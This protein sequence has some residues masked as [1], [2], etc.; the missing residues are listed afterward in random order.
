MRKG[1]WVRSVQASGSLTGVFRTLKFGTSNAGRVQQVQV[2]VSGSLYI[3]PDKWQS[4]RIYRSC[5]LQGVDLYNQF[6]KIKTPIL[7]CDEYTVLL[8]IFLILY[9]LLTEMEARWRSGSALR[10]Q[11]TGPKFC[12][13]T[14]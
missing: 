4:Y 11:P 13:R 8:Y 1:V 6:K 9:S 14:G 5:R 2:E 12:P 7:I 10:S 3:T